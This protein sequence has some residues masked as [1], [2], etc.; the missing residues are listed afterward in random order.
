MEKL[1]EKLKEYLHMETEIP[2]EE[3][4][5][6]YKE[7]IN[8]LNTTFESLDKDQRLKARYICSIVQANAEAR[9]KRNK[10]KAKLYRKISTKCTFWSDA[11]NFHLLKDG[12]SQQEIDA[13]TET[14]NEAI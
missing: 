13:A 11:I 3:F 5:E 7:L 10:T 1:F 14:I 8:E 12:L 9:A 6:Y 4:S 2:F